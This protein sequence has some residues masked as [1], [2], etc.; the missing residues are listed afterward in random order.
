VYHA[1]A[2][3]MHLDKPEMEL[4]RLPYD[5]PTKKWEKEGVVNNVVFPLVLH[6]LK[7]T[8]IS[9]TAA[10]KHIAVAKINLLNCLVN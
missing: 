5:S 8:F 9:T 1:K 10:D 2:A 4:S 3:L 6:C 7:M